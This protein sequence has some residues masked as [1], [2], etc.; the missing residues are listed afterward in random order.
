MYQKQLILLL[1]EEST[2]CF[3]IMKKIIILLFTFFFIVNI[4]SQDLNLPK[5]PNQGDVFC[6]IKDTDE[7]VKIN[8]KLAKIIKDGKLV[9]LQYKLKN[10][11]YDI[12]ITNCIDHKT[13]K[14]FNTEGKKI[15]NK[16]KLKRKEQRLKRK[17]ERLERRNKKK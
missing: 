2:L 16:N 5:N 8:P 13:I 12:D 4:N 10:L 17:K 14:A 11:N 7:W 3:S 6:K 9:G 1:K 15:K